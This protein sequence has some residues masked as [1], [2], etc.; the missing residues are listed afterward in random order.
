MELFEEI[1]KAKEDFPKQKAITDEFSKHTFNFYQI[2][3]IGL[4]IGFFFLGI[5]FGNLFATCQAYS[6][7]YSDACVVTEFNYSIMI[8]IWFIGTL[9]SVFYFSIGHII[10][11]LSNINE[12]L[13]KFKL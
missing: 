13:S 9:L 10:A 3:G 4:M 12:K 7:F 6:Y 11:I 1:S 5:V 2:F 8:C